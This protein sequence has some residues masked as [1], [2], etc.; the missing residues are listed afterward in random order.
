ML[1]TNFNNNE[2][3]VIFKIG[4]I[5]TKKIEKITKIPTEFLIKILPATTKSKPSLIKPPTIGIELE[6]AYLAA[7][8]LMPSKVALVSP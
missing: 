8:I 1:A 2:N 3:T 4:E 5:K 7:L 6:I